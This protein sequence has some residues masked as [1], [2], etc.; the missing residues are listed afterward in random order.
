M[1]GKRLIVSLF[2]CGLSFSVAAENSPEGLTRPE[3]QLLFSGNTGIGIHVAKN[4]SVHDYYG[5]KGHFTSWRSNGEKL[6]GHWWISK[7]R[8]A[9][10]V[11]YKHRPDKSF[12]RAVVKNPRGG[13]DKIREKDGKVLVHYD[14]ISKGKVKL[15]AKKPN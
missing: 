15:K 9:I 10:C 1:I 2:L 8:H 12:C 4:L 5:E 13:Y 14:A 11:K 6:K 3:L 7:Q